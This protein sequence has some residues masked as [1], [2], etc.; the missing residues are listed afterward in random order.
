MRGGFGCA[1]LHFLGSHIF[2]VSGYRPLVTERIGK[3]TIAIAPELI[4]KRHIH[5]GARLNGTVEKV[6]Y[7]LGVKEQ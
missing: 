3:L 6:I 7:F 1:T 5:F 4:L 2:N